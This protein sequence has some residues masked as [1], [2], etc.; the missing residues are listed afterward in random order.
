MKSKI[1]NAVLDYADMNIYYDEWKELRASR[2][3]AE[4]N[5]LSKLKKVIK[6]M[7]NPFSTQLNK[8]FLFN[9]K[10]STQASKMWKNNF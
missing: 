10:S 1:L 5:H 4:Q 8:D 2:I 3:R 7:V 6:A 9:I